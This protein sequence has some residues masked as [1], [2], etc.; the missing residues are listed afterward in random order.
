[1]KTEIKTYA[2]Y[3]IYMLAVLCLGFLFVFYYVLYPL[4]YKNDINIYSQKY[5]VNNALIASII[6]VE[7]SYIKEAQSS[8]GAV[9]LMQILPTTAKWICEQNSINFKEQDL[10]VPSYNIKLGTLYIKYLIDKFDNIDNVIVA[11][12]AGEGVVANWLKNSNLSE[13]GKTLKNI[14]YNETS[15]YLTKVKR[16]MKVYSD[17]L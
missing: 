8:K 13:D 11:Y 16:A 2:K 3:V 1:M 14:P 12:N 6:C 10:F 17:R 9:G 5:N 15:N 4:K 7:S